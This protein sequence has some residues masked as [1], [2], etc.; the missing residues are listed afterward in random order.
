MI[1]ANSLNFFGKVVILIYEAL[2][3]Y[4]AMGFWEWFVI[5]AFGT[6]YPNLVFILLV[7]FKCQSVGGYQIQNK[8]KGRKTSPNR[9]K[10]ACL[11]EG[12]KSI[13]PS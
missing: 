7:Y 1:G 6:V 10:N 4:R 5:V 2:T 3:Y 12:Q 11:Q 13:S 9:I 8:N